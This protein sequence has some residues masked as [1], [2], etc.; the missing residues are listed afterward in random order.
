MLPY[1][2]MLALPGYMTLFTK[3][4][5]GLAL[6]LCFTVFLIFL[7]LRYEVGMDWN[8][9][10]AKHQQMK[11]VP[12]SFMVYGPEPLSNV[13]MWV[14]ANYGFD[15]VLSDMVSSLLLLIGVF[16]L[17]RRTPNP[18]LGILAATPYLLLVTGLSILRQAPAIGLILYAISRWDQ[19]RSW[20]KGFWI[21][22]ATLFHTSAL[23]GIVLVIQGLRMRRSVKI[24]MLCVVTFPM[25]FVIARLSVFSGS[26][27]FYQEAYLGENSIVSSGALMHM[28]LVWLPSLIYLIFRKQLAEYI[29]DNRIVTVGAV[30][31]LC[32]VVIYF[33]SSTVGSRIILYFYFVPIMVYPAIGAAADRER[34]GLI[35]SV[36]I[37]FHFFVLIAWLAFANNAHAHFPYEN[38]LQLWL[39]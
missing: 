33:V 34:R 23:F 10:E 8:N 9:Y 7:G 31:A 39:A 19:D 15:V 14:S 26:L 4:N 35:L 24:A 32:T 18:W 17:S 38:F 5:S 22:L 36:I 21:G 20:L 37:A 13:L 30:L 12:F 28:G 3:R 11:M 16:A 2:G 6:I 1:L 29:F 25:L 27:A